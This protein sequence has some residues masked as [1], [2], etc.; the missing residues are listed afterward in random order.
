MSAS[1]PRMPVVFL[2]HGGGPW[3]FVELG[4]GENRGTVAYGGTFATA[5]LSAYH[6]G[7]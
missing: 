1:I 6:F 7:T 3:P 4:F 5:A 2:P